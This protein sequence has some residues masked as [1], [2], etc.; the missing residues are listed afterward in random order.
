MSLVGREV[1][2]G[3]KLMGYG[4]AIFR[5]TQPYGRYRVGVGDGRVGGRSGYR[6]GIYG[7]RGGIGSVNLG[8]RGMVGI[9]FSDIPFDVGLILGSLLSGEGG[10]V[11]GEGGGVS[12]VGGSVSGLGGGVMGHGLG[13]GGVVGVSGEGGGG[14]LGLLLL[15]LGQ[16]L[17]RVLVQGDVL[18]GGGVVG[19]GKLRGDIVGVSSGLGDDGAGGRSVR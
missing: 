16:I 9:R 8:K 18:G 11:S 13:G 4:D 5:G 1:R 17:D 12:G 3:I 2:R 14:M 19:G 6:G 10:G 15:M 7:N